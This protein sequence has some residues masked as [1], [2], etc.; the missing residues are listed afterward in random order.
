MQL[1][2]QLRGP[3]N[4]KHVCNLFQDVIDTEVRKL[5][6]LK[7]DFKSA[8]GIDWKQGASVPSTSVSARSA[9]ALNAPVAQ[10]GD[11]VQEFKAQKASKVTNRTS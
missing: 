5:L 4:F 6:T 7:S 1:F 8:T 3:R 10:Q 2:S 11:R 9:E